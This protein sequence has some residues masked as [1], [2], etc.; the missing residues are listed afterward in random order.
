V[1]NTGLSPLTLCRGV[2]GKGVLHYFFG[3]G[4]YL[5]DFSMRKGRIAAGLE[6]AKPLPLWYVQQS[7][8][9]G[10]I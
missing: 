4:E 7:Q 6:E 10:R 5:D 1:S 2:D 3:T 9:A 8:G